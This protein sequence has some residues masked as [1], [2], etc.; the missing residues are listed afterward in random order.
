MDLTYKAIRLLRF[1]FAYRVSGMENIRDGGPAIYVANHLDSAGPV[2][3]VLSLPVRFYP[4][5]I[6]EMSDP[7][8]APRYLYDDFV[9]PIWH[10]R[11]RFGMAVSTVLSWFTVR[12]I[13]GMR[14]IPVDRRRHRY[15]NCFRRSLELLQ[16]GQNLLIFPE[17]PQ[18]ETDPETHLRPFLSGFLLL[19]PLYQQLAA[20]P[21][22]VYPLAVYRP[23]RIIA[24][25]RPL[26][27]ES[28][29]ARRGD[30]ARRAGRQLQQEVAVLYRTML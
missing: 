26:F 10:L 15:M 8:R 1:P 13:Q 3:V 30:D 27:F 24:V 2:E 7:R 25:G 14:C 28:H 20:A 22:P 12:L 29:S 6:A 21:L 17:D 11:G 4:W 5:V 23:R 18:G 19:C 9:H 16:Q